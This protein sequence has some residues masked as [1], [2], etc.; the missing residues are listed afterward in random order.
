MG[1]KPGATA[2][3]KSHWI[4]WVWMALLPICFLFGMWFGARAPVVTE[5]ETDRLVCGVVTNRLGSG[6]GISCVP[7]IPGLFD[8]RIEQ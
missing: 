2:A 7:K 3:A 5:I 1:R 8:E 4:G 6:R